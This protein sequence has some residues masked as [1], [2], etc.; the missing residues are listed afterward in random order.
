[1]DEPSVAKKGIHFSQCNRDLRNTSK[2]FLLNRQVILY[3]RVM[4]IINDLLKFLNL[5]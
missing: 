1:M 2:I 4:T 3:P 5:M